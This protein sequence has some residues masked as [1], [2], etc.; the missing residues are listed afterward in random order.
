[1][2]AAGAAFGGAALSGEALA[3]GEEKYTYPDYREVE[4]ILKERRDIPSGVT[5]YVAQ[6]FRKNNSSLEFINSGR[7]HVDTKNILRHET[8]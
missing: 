6:F 8:L 4:G 2:R 3:Q 1:M 7:S 5:Q